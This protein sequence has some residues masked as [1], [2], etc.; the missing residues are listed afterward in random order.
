MVSGKNAI[1]TGARRGI[2]HATVEI[3]AKNGANVWA[4]AREYDQGFENWCIEL[5]KSTGCKVRPLYFDLCD[6]EAIKEAFKKIKQ[7]KQS[8][9]I[10]VNVAGCVHNA[11]FSMTSMKIMEELFDINYFK[12]IQFTQYI[13]KLMM[14]QKTGSIIN[15]SSSGALDGNAGRTAY[16]A[17]KAALISTTQT[18]ARELGSMGIRVNAIA[19][20]LIDTDMAN[21]NT[22][23]E[24]MQNE[25]EG[26]SLRRIGTPEEVANV[27]MFLA[28]DLSS[29]VTG[30]IWRVDGGM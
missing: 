9:D 3:L 5:E 25:I 29:Y 30:Q 2:G 15:I 6:D 17:T 26:T 22:P 28:S 16:N 21:K 27:I 7:E 23:I 4:C 8:I 18:M 11:N 20:G 13:L 1:V 14:K 19:P 24:I 10:L 12:Q